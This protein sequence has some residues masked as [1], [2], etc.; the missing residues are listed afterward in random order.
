M[1]KFARMISLT[2]IFLCL[3]V[4]TNGQKESTVSGEA[5]KFIDRYSAEWNELRYANN[6]A[7]WNSNIKI[8]EGDDTNSKSAN[9][10]G[11]KLSAFIGSKAN[12][13]TARDYLK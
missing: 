6:L 5:Q 2:L 10:T 11:E 3:V 9:A 1:K 4:V 7:Q 8:V 13:D 12:I